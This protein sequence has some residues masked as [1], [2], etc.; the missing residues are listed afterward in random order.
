MKLLSL[1]ALA[2]LT[3]CSASNAKA[4]TISITGS[5]TTNHTHVI[6]YLIMVLSPWHMAMIQSRPY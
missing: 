4:D 1:V 3:I 6:S 5:N 2:A